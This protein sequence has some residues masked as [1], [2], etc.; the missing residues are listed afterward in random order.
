MKPR[1]EISKA[2]PRSRPTTTPAIAPFDRPDF[3][4]PEISVLSP[5]EDEGSNLEEV[6]VALSDTQ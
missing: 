6:N 4:V 1:R 3:P 2:I 5:N